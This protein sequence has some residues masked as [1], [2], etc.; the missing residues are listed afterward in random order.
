MVTGWSHWDLVGGDHV[1]KKMGKQLVKYDAGL[2]KSTRPPTT[3]HDSIMPSITQFVGVAIILLSSFNGAL[4]SL[5][6]RQAP[7]PAP[8]SPTLTFKP[9][10][11]PVVAC[12][13]TNFSWDYSGPDLRMT[14]FVTNDNVKQLDPPSLQS[15]PTPSPT[16]SVGA[17]PLRFTLSDSE[18]LAPTRNTSFTWQI[19]SIPRG[20]YVLEAELRTANYTARGSPFFVEEYGNTTCLKSLED[21]HQ[22]ASGASSLQISLFSIISASIVGLAFFGVL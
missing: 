20:W 14:L 6:P 13:S 12:N 5:V 11:N 3:S 17:I 18:G 15:P 22:A 4:T 8:S 16:A 9:T 21:K 2:S 1:V 19:V 10:S 7:A